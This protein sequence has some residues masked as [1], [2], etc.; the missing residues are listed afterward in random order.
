MLRRWPDFSYRHD[1]EFG[2]SQRRDGRAPGRSAGDFAA[3]LGRSRY[4]L[5]ALVM[6]LMS[7]IHR[8]WATMREAMRLDFGKSIASVIAMMMPVTR[9]TGTPS[10]RTAVSLYGRQM[11]ARAATAITGGIA[12]NASA[13]AR[14]RR[15]TFLA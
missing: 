2:G 9:V 10:G 1:E 7:L 8:P 3:S 13:A 5:P 14:L 6:R 12:S 4:L 15:G 11:M